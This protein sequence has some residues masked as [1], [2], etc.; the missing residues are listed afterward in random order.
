MPRDNAR[1]PF[2]LFA[3]AHGDMMEVRDPRLLFHAKKLTICAIHGRRAPRLAS[4]AAKARRALG[5]NGEVGVFCR[6]AHIQVAASMPPHRSNRDCLAYRRIG[7]A[8]RGAAS[9]HEV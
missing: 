3:V 9:E 1:Y 8:V 2:E 5:E 7:V 4:E 6:Q